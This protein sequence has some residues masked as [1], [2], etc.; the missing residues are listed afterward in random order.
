MNTKQ[1]CLHQL[2]IVLQGEVNM[3]FPVIAYKEN[4]CRHSEIRADHSI[5]FMLSFTKFF[6]P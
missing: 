3:V 2:T 4:V 6:F 1:D 5:Y